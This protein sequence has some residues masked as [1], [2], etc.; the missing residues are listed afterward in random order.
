[1]IDVKIGGLLTLNAQ[2]TSF[3]MTMLVKLQPMNF[4]DEKLTIKLRFVNLLYFAWAGQRVNLFYN[5]HAYSWKLVVIEL[6]LGS[7]R[8]LYRVVIEC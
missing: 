3:K 8:M 5:Y 2:D 4:K 7:Y 1:M 6:W